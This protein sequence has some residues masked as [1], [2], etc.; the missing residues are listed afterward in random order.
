MPGGIGLLCRQVT[1]I[2]WLTVE[3]QCRDGRT[4]FGQSL[5][6][7]PGLG[8]GHENLAPGSCPHR[9]AVGCHLLSNKANDLGMVYP[10]EPQREE[11]LACWLPLRRI[12]QSLK[13][14]HKG[15]R[16]L[17]DDPVEQHE[18]RDAPPQAASQ[19]QAALSEKN[20]FFR[21]LP[22]AQTAAC[23]ERNRRQ[24]V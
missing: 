2:G 21:S 19:F 16:S 24:I 15:G 5:E 18:F 7:A 1:R 17:Q 6:R 13:H 9:E 4:Q 23:R 10:F 12:L 14:T 22:I 3:V 20:W 8:I 11:L